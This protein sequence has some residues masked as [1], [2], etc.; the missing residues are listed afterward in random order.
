M[1]SEYGKA[2]PEAT[3]E[4]SVNFVCARRFL[5]T[6][7]R[8]GGR[9]RRRSPKPPQPSLFV[10][11][12]ALKIRPE[13]FKEVR[14]CLRGDTEGSGTEALAKWGRVRGAYCVEPQVGEHGRSVHADHLRDVENRM[15][16]AISRQEGAAERVPRA[17]P[18]CL[19]AEIARIVAQCGGEAGMNI[20]F[21]ANLAQWSPA[22]VENSREELGSTVSGLYSHAKWL[23]KPVSERRRRG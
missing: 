4:K 19:L 9:G 17:M 18:T 13:F 2:R 7:L 20:P 3:L 22:R 11:N 12:G 16:F 21:M 6:Y 14:T 5:P 15:P 23:P 8:A 10:Q 1:A